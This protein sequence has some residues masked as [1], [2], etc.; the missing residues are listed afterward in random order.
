MDDNEQTTVYRLDGTNSV[1]PK[2]QPTD[3]PQATIVTGPVDLSAMPAAA[4]TPP[5]D[6]PGFNSR[7]MF[8]SRHDNN[9]H[10]SVYGSPSRKNSRHAFTTNYHD[11]EHDQYHDHDHDQYHDH[12]QGN[13]KRGLRI[14][15][16]PTDPHREQQQKQGGFW[17]NQKSIGN[18]LKQSPTFTRTYM[19]FKGTNTNGEAYND[20]LDG[21]Q[22]YPMFVHET[23]NYVFAQMCV[24]VSIVGSMYYHKDSVN[25]YLNENPTIMWYPIVGTFVT[26][27]S[28]FCCVK[29]SS[30]CT[31]QILFWMFTVFCG[32]MVGVSTIQYSPEVVLNATVTL[33]VVV[34]FLNIWAYSM[35]KRGHD[36]T[37]MAPTLL[38]G[39]LAIITIGILNAFIQSTLIEN[40]ITFG[41]VIVFSL[42]LVYDLNRLYV[43]AE[44]NDY[45]DP[46]VA[47]I[48]IYL[49]VI[50]MFLNLLRIFNGGNNE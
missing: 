6:T 49:D 17:Q 26:M 44:E 29:R 31:R 15:Q 11:H 20:M 8:N 4:A 28:L 9:M 2:S 21:R 27:L 12:T 45:A 43:G 32:A 25:N 40:C 50:N 7:A 24:T 42:L 48:N 1:R 16:N 38:G 36:L 10:E 14:P 34:G 18:Q 33:V 35:A 13:S 30:N 19:N 37:Y 41:S 5:D 47:A 46:L 39:L 22:S 23:L 3:I